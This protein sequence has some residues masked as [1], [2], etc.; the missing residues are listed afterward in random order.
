MLCSLCPRRA[1]LRSSRADMLVSLTVVVLDFRR[2]EFVNPRRRHG[3]TGVIYSLKWVMQIGSP[4]LIRAFG[5]ATNGPD[6]HCYATYRLS[7]T[8]DR[9]CTLDVEQRCKWIARWFER[10]RLHD[11][12]CTGPFRARFSIQRSHGIV[13]RSA[14]SSSAVSHRSIRAWLDSDPSRPR[15]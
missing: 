12:K 15:R 7:G 8:L 14:F 9:L 13:S 4:T 2:G 10:R 11:P 6:L 3:F 5:H 1:A